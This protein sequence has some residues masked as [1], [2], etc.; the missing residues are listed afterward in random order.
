M[1]IT[2]VRHSS[3]WGSFSAA[4]EDGRVIGVTPFEGDPSPD[5]LISAVPDIVH[6]PLRI[7][8]P[9]VRKSWL[10]QGPRAD[11]PGRGGEPFVP[12]AWSEALDLVAAELRRVR[13][14]YGSP[15]IL[16]GCSGWSS[17]GRFH[18]AQSQMRRFLGHAGGYTGQVTNYS[19]GAAM[20]ILPRVVGDYSSVE[21][22]IT[23]WAAVTRH[24][25]LIVAFGGMVTK[26][27]SIAS[28]GFGQHSSHNLLRQASDAGLRIVNI[29]PLRRDSPDLPGNEWLPIRPNADTAV[30]LGLAHRIISTGRHDQAFLDRYTVGFARLKAYILGESDGVAKTPEWAAKLSDIPAATIRDLADDMARLPTMLTATWSIQRAD[31]GEQ[32]YWMLIALAAMLGGIGKP[33]TG[34]GFGYGSI[35]GRGSNRPATPS[36]ALPP[37]VNPTGRNIPAARL[38]EMLER[39][40]D[41]CQFNGRWIEFPDVRLIYWAGGNPFHHHQDLNRL[42]RAWRKPETIIVHEPWWTPIARHADIVLPATTTLERNDIG[43]NGRDR[44]IMAMQQAVPPQGQAMSD[45]AIYTALSERLG[46]KDAFTEGRD[47][48]AWLRH[49]YEDN[50]ARIAKLG[51]A[52]AD[53]DAFWARGHAEMP[54]APEGEEFTLLKRFRDDPAGA[55]LQTPS[56]R[57][58]L[59]SDAIASFAYDDCPG[60]PTWLEPREWLA[61]PLAARYP[62][63]LL[64]PQPATRLHGQMDQ[65]RVSQAAKIKGREPVLINPTDAEARG[66]KAGD[67][68]RLFNDRGQCL[69]GAELSDELRPGV[70]SLATGAWF[71]LERPGVA[72]SL[73]IHGNP[74]VLTRDQ[75]ASQLSQ[76]ASAQSCLVEIAR[77]D[78]PLPALHVD[79]PPAIEARA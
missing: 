24:A 12:V 21:G 63:H 45:F 57:I 69:A 35:N 40:G 68:V 17:A 46:I 33:G 34:F 6:S 19:Y 50:R 1:A 42:L 56:G 29:S 59:F 51:I 22:A 38:T 75:G 62:L 8:R 27:W 53:F 25:K 13:A 72:G 47:E 54:P 30:M 79:K 44:F 26:N 78:G 61:S 39:P 41:G 14:T 37:G 64:S 71:D 65:G 58:E 2:H 5:A 18:H 52:I 4:V 49:L 9:H 36:I 11:S 48:M 31:F 3:H 16:G 55:P 28:G 32:P 23:S 7:D 10:E 74:N 70:V 76:C 43:V 20:T 67:I 77:W 15:S 73:E 66:I 60:H